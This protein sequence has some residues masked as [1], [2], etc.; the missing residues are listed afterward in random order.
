MP[1]MSSSVEIVN[2]KTFKNILTDK[3]GREDIK[4]NPMEF[5]QLSQKELKEA[6]KSFP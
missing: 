3:F 1:L 5:P 4:L 2:V 6:G